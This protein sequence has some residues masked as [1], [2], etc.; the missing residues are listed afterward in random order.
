MSADQLRAYN[1]AIIEIASMNNLPLFNVYRALN[2]LPSSGLE[3]NGAT[4]SVSPSGAGDLSGSAVA[5]YGVNALNQYA[6]RTLSALRSAIF[7][8]ALVP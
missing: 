7:P 2:E 4:P 3:G 6:L 1:E 8:D 5:N